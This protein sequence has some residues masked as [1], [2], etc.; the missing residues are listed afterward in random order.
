M[1]GSAVSL[2][3]WI[4]AGGWLQLR[5]SLP[6]LSALQSRCDGRF[7]VG[8][9]NHVA[10]VR[11]V[12]VDW[13]ST[14][15]FVQTRRFAGRIDAWTNSMK[16]VSPPRDQEVA[17][18]C[19]MLLSGHVSPNRMLSKESGR[20]VLHMHVEKSWETPTS[21]SDTAAF[22]PIR[23]RG[24]QQTLSD[25]A[26]LSVLVGDAAPLPSCAHVPIDVERRVRLLLRFACYFQIS[27]RRAQ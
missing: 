15:A 26:L 13:S 5:L 10:L 3:A 27:W 21:P 17:S 7:R 11:T 1:A 8:V 16:V 6:N 22:A 9:A 20:Q 24:H 25:V 12:F 19:A 4:P 18:Q 14:W 2:I 23:L